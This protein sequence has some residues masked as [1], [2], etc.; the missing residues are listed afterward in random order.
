MKWAS[1]KLLGIAVTGLFMAQ[2][3]PADTLQYNGPAYGPWDS[4]FTIKDALPT[5]L[6]DSGVASGGFKMTNLSGPTFPVGSSFTAWCVDIYDWLNISSSGTQYT[7]QTGN[8]FYSSAQSYK[9][10]DLER[11]ASYVFDHSTA[12]FTNA[13]WAGGAA[14]NVQSAAF[15]LA[16]WEIVADNAGHGGY[17]VTSGD[18]KVTAGDSN[19]IVLANNWLGVVNTG[20]YAIDQELDVWGKNC[21]NGCTRDLA[22]F[23]PTPIPEPEIYSMLIAGLGLM[24]F[25][26][27]RRKQIDRAL[28]G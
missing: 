22:A 27:R 8:N 7:L 17:S 5:L 21:T 9:D 1:I 11:L 15:Q 14:A 23:S 19:A 18:F 6:T 2:A 28:V 24:G 4:G 12:A 10:T 3:V 25:V 13:A 20:S 26:A 16:V